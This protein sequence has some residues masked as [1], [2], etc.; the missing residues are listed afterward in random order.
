MLNS[1]LKNCIHCQKNKITKHTKSEYSQ[2]QAPDDRFSVVHID[3]IGPYLPSNSY[4]YCM[5][6]I[7]RFTSW[8][9]VVPLTNI[10]AESI[11]RAFYEHWITRFGVPTC[12][13]TDRNS[14]YFRTISKFGCSM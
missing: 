5:T 11:A 4:T 12:V 9:E 8:M 3:L 14:I 10:T 1:G 6:C 2:F 13:I 7:D